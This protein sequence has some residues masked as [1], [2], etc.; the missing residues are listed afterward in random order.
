MTS[1]QI[2]FAVLFVLL[3]NRGRLK[4]IVNSIFKAQKLQEY[5]NDSLIV[6]LKRKTGLE[7]E[8]KISPSNK[9]NAYSPSHPLKP[10]FVLTKG[11]IKNLINDELEWLAL[12]ESGHCA[13]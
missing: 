5:K 1:T 3:A 7:F 8:I 9:V 11:A 12:H 13:L 6:V 4:I 2:L 10:L